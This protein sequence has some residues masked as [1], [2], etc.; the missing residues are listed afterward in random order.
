MGDVSKCFNH[1]GEMGGEEDFGQDSTGL[2][3]GKPSSN[4]AHP[5]AALST[6]G[7]RLKN[8]FGNPSQRM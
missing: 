8:Y 2:G 3:E 7:G 5:A 6:F 4:K 1:S